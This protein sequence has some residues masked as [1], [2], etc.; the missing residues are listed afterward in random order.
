MCTSFL[1]AHEK[2]L[3]ER[4]AAEIYEMKLALQNQIRHSSA[5]SD[6]LSMW[7]KTGPVAKV[8]GVKPRTVK[9]IW[10]RQT[11]VQATKHLWASEA[12][13]GTMFACKVF[14]RP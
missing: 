14:I 10:N 2:M 8:F 9:Y 11:W 13:Q 3:T 1:I 5:C 12:E 4:E 7:G 6:A